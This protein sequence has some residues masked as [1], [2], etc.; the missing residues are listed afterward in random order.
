[1][2]YLFILDSLGTTELLVILGA[3]LIFF[4]P[5]KLPQLSRRDAQVAPAVEGVEPEA[6]MDEECAIEDETAEVGLP[7]LEQELRG[8]LKS[9]DRMNAESVIDQMRCRIGK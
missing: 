4:G 2:M 8:G 5:R 1:M 9:L 6:G 7:W 3:A